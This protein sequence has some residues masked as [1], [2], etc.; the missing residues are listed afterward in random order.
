MRKSVLLS[1]C[2]LVCFACSR[3]VDISNQIVYLEDGTEVL[4]SDFIDQK[5]FSIVVFTDGECSS[6]MLELKWWQDF[7]NS[8]K[9]EG[10]QYLYVINTKSTEKFLLFRMKQIAAYP[11]IL[12][13]SYS[14]RAENKLKSNT[15]AIVINKNQ[16]IIYQGN[17]LKSKEQVKFK[18]LIDEI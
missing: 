14:I 9:K 10:L 3:N 18:A 12:E 2:I 6:C 4:S 17:P 7:F 15:T 16:E 1:I 11:V 13:E 5:E 8:I